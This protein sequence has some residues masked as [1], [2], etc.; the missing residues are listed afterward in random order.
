MF[1]PVEHQGE[2]VLTKNGSLDFGEIPED[3]ASVIKRQAGKIR[4]RIGEHVEGRKDNFGERHIERPE[5]MTALLKCG[6][7]SARE[8]I[9]D[10]CKSYDAIYLGEKGALVLVKFHTERKNIAIVK[11]RPSDSGDF[12]DV[13][14][15]YPSRN[16]G[17]NKKPLLWERQRQ[18]S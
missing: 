6:Y 13:Q 5:R 7:S 11:L 1:Y 17:K 12:Y 14:T 3:I 10:V 8:F 18:R 9:E 15:G 4:L 2:F 16:S